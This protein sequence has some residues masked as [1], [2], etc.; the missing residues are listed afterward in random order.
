MQNQHNK[1]SKFLSYIL[2]HHPQDI[3][4]HPDEQGWVA[5]DELI[6]AVNAHGKHLD[7]DLLQQVVAGNDK[8]RFAFSPD[9]LR[10]RANQ[11][12]SIRIELGLE[13]A[14]PPPYLYHGTATRFMQSINKHG[15]TPGS[16]HHVHLS[17]DHITAKQ[18]GT[19]HGMPV[20]L[21]VDA[22]RMHQD[23]NVFYLSANGVWL[24]DKVAPTYFSIYD[25]STNHG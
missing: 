7:L 4:L 3:G 24:T 12:H 15:L 16:R 18:V 13:P 10:I 19:R 2:R 25:Q 9:G 17:A 22:G 23:G 21:L 11:G 6:Q 5:V 1:I 8:Q 20:V 14:V